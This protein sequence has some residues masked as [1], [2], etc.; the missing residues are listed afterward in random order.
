MVS[1]G[2]PGAVR[3]AGGGTI[4][5]LRGGWGLTTQRFT[6][7][8]VAVQPAVAGGVVFTGS[9]EGWVKGFAAG[10]ADRAT[11]ADG[12]HRCDARRKHELDSPV[13]GAPAIS[14]GRLFVGTADGTLVAFT[15]SPEPA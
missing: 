15:P 5:G 8:T 11:A 14:G 9:V 13:T 12:E 3:R 7:C 10:C 1:I 6:G 2:A 4:D